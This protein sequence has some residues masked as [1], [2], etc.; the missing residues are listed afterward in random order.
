MA[1][2][3]VGNQVTLYSPNDSEIVVTITAPGRVSV[4]GRNVITGAAVTPQELYETT[5][6]TTSAG[7]RV[8]LEAIN[9]DAFYS[10][11]ST[12]GGGTVDAAGVLAAMQDMDATQESQARSAIGASAVQTAGTTISSSRSLTSADVGKRFLVDTSSGAV[13][14]TT[15]TGVFSG[16]NLTAITFVRSGAN[17]LSF[18]QGSSTTLR[19]PGTITVA[20]GGTVMLVNHPTLDNNFEVVG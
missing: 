3:S 5:T 2:L 18:S 10:G 11:P 9:V 17:T 12:T 4:N 20:N 15:A 1:T 16:G 6:I 13:V 8:T 14:I 19:D 7:D